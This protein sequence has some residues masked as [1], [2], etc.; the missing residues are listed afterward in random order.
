MRAG[1]YVEREFNTFFSRPE[2]KSI[3]LITVD[4]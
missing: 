1:Y 3:L 4:D 2:G